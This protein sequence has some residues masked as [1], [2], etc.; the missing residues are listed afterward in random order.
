MSGRGRRAQT[1]TLKSTSQSPKSSWAL[2]NLDLA[3]KTR[4]LWD[5]QHSLDSWPLSLARRYVTL[6]VIV[7]G[8][9]MVMLN[10]SSAPYLLNVF[11]WCNIDC[12]FYY[13]FLSPHLMLLQITGKGPLG[14]FGLETGIPLGQAS[15]GLLAFI[16][17]FL[18]AAV[19]EGE[20]T[21]N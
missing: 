6:V 7:L 20:Q 17:F 21:R 15:I 12:P 4:C 19:F 9:M 11:I 14:Q 1:R 18:V 10:L 5:E 8:F 13:V 2:L 16:S 3:R